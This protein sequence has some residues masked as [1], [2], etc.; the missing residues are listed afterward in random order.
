MKSMLR[1][2]W[3]KKERVV[4]RISVEILR[5]NDIKESYKL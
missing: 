4:N 3:T 2:N 5:C 1:T